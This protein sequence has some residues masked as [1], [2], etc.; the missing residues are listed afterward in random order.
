[1]RSDC[2]KEKKN[3]RVTTPQPHKHTQMLKLAMDQ[4]RETSENCSLEEMV[5]ERNAFLEPFFC[6]SECLFGDCRRID[7]DGSATG[8]Q[9]RTL[10]PSEGWVRKN[11][12][13]RRDWKKRQ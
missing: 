6:G 11:E 13:T 12:H 5:A 2:F 7:L 10:L 3:S 9:R 4:K 8:G 1:M